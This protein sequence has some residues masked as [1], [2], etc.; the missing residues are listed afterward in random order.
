[1][2]RKYVQY[3]NGWLS[4][5][6]HYVHPSLNECLEAFKE[7]GEIQTALPGRGQRESQLLTSFCVVWRYTRIHLVLR[8]VPMDLLWA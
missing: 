1:M 7:G 6:L 4:A 5:R 3:K 2:N 8:T